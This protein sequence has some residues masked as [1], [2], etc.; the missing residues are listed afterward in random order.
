MIALPTS[1]H[2]NRMVNT[3]AN[4]RKRDFSHHHKA[5][6]KQAA[7]IHPAYRDFITK[8]IDNKSLK[9]ERTWKESYIEDV[10]ESEYPTGLARKRK[11][12]IHTD[13]YD[14]EALPH[15]L[16]HAVDFWCGGNVAL[17]TTVVLE[18]NK[19]LFDIFAEEF[20]SLHKKLLGEVLEECRVILDREIEE[21]ASDI[22]MNNFSLYCSLARP[23]D[24]KARHEIQ[25]ELY[26][27]GF[28]EAYYQLYEKRCF[29]GLNKRIGIILDALSSRYDLTLSML[30][31]HSPSYYQADP[32]NAVYEFFANA[33]EAKVTRSAAEFEALHRYL[34]KSFDAFEKL[35]AIAYNHIQNNKRFTDLETKKRRKEDE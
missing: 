17:S 26:E 23:L 25:K 16:G 27:S 30:S 9:I 35:F 14:V 24:E 2:A 5:L 8:I 15:E 22:L 31:H 32:N 1:V 21:G 4:K 33:F 29:R 34:P 19:T 12:K 11:N 18:D 7:Y 28:V 10:D 3:L 13:I 20:A 6:V